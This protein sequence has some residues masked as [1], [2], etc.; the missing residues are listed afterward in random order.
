MPHLTRN[1]AIRIALIFII[2]TGLW[3]EGYGQWKQNESLTGGSIVSDIISFKG[4]LYCAIDAV[5][6]Y[7]SSNQGDSWTKTS[8]PPQPN[9]SYF[10]CN[11]NKLVAVSYGKTYSTLD[12]TQWI[13]GPGPEAFVNGLGFDGEKVVAA[14]SS[15]IYHLMEDGVTW[16]QF[17]DAKTKVN[18][19]SIAVRGDT[20]W[21]SVE[22]PN[23]GTLLTTVDGGVTWSE[24]NKGTNLINSIVIDKNDVLI[25]I[26]N[27]GIYK[28]SNQGSNWQV[29][30]NNS[31]YGGSLSG[32]SSKLSFISTYSVYTSSNNGETWSQKNDIPYYNYSVIYA[33]D[34]YV[35]VGLWG[36]GVVRTPIAGNGAWQFV[37]KGIMAHQIHDILVKD[38]S[39]FVGLENSFVR[40]S[41]DE[42][43]TWEQKKDSYNLFGAH[44]D[45]IVSTDFGLFVDTRSAGV[46]RSSDN[47]NSWVF[48]SNGTSNVSFA[49]LIADGTTLY[50]C[51]YAGEN[52]VFKSTDNGET[53][54]K[55]GDIPS[56]RK[57]YANGNTI[58]AGTYNGLFQS[59]D[60][61]ET[62]TK[63]STGLPDQS[64]GSM[65]CLGTILYAA[66]QTDGLHKTIDGGSTWE[67][68]NS[69]YI[70]TLAVKNNT[71]FIGTSDNGLLVSYDSGKT[72]QDFAA[73]LPAGMVTTINFTQENILI[74]K[75][76]SGLWMRKI[77]Q[78]IP[79][80]LKLYTAE[81]N[82]KFYVDSAV[83][84]QSDQ[85]LFSSQGTPISDSDLTSYISVTTDN[86]NSV[87]FSA[88][89]DAEKKHIRL[90]IKN[91]EQGKL[92][93]ITVKPM[94]NDS[95][96]N[97]VATTGK[98]TAI[99]NSVPVVSDLHI[100]TQE[101]HSIFLS[102]EVFS[103][104]F[105]DADDQ[106]LA[107]IIIKSLP[108][109]GVLKVNEVNVT[110]NQ[111][112]P[113]LSLS[114]LNYVP[115][116][117]FSGIDNF[118]WNGSDGMDF[119]PADATVTIDVATITAIQSEA[120]DGIQVFPNPVSSKLTI[121]VPTTDWTLKVVDIV[122]RE[123]KFPST[124]NL[125]NKTCEVNF[126]DQPAGIY[127]LNIG[128]P[129]GY[130]LLKKIS[131]K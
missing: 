79:P 89:I 27:E 106:E 112:I 115:K 93:N 13:S 72:S 47:G 62:W 26:S 4:N 81:N 3:H 28:S 88:K 49:D 59:R 14:T 84:I 108:E 127:I 61:G 43:L 46:V 70:Y 33:T 37:N 50:A 36:G 92:Y 67:K 63:I 90:F 6:I 104:A 69:E 21:A 120:F 126:T 123:V 122:G 83:F 85:G 101:N 131:K 94:Q 110:L 130:H 34:Q 116:N 107:E 77:S 15:G 100:N 29:V 12:G 75:G 113:V 11:S 30:R 38:A 121:E 95:G 22:Y 41:K 78:I 125:H 119:A 82:D 23:P 51:A 32:G 118:N 52:G 8:V 66:T 71:L 10:A 17:D 42:G 53:W 35:F 56:I 65:V 9:F 68:L 58:Y 24:V 2:V 74:G 19:K 64:V 7:K 76:A 111:I 55:K 114:Q 87:S 39:I 25:N 54:V 1:N 45:K 60:E 117:N 48:K 91:A 44:G 5:G 31:S 102:K 97:S 103:T 129:T 99:I 20:I 18:I 16:A 105:E 98:F 109:N 128:L 80:Y 73:S 57:L 86:E 124:H 96:L 40:L